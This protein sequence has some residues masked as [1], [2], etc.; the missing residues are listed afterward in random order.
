MYC[1]SRV[2]IITLNQWKHINLFIQ[3]PHLLGFFCGVYLVFPRESALWPSDG[4]LLLITEPCFTERSHGN[5]SFGLIAISVSLLIYRAALVQNLKLQCKCSNGGCCSNIC[6][7]L[8]VS[9]ST[10]RPLGNWNDWSLWAALLS[11][12]TSTRR[13]WAPVWSEH[14]ESSNASSEKVTAEWTTTK[15]L[16]SPAL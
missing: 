11:T 7:F 4:D 10:W 13:C 8:S 12:R 16:I 6:P 14:L 3:L 15:K 2:F 9:V 1:C 5:R